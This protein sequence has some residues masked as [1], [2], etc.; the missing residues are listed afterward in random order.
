MKIAL[1]GESPTDTDSVIKLLTKKWSSGFSYLTLL[2]NMNGSV[3]DN[4]K[5]KHLLRAQFQFEKPDLVIFIRDLDS[6]EP[7]RKKRLERLQYFRTNNKIV[8]ER[9]VFLL[10]VFEIEALLLADR[11]G[12]ENFFNVKIG[13]TKRPEEIQ[14]PKEFIK[15]KCKD[16]FEGLNSEIFETLSFNKV[17]D[18]PSFHEFIVEFK[19]RIA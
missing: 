15:N 8:A 4:P 6:I 12:L 3:L 7:N 17:C 14:H 5:T 1:V 18:H 16:Y 10:C 19:S 13:L 11:E 9:G 2:N